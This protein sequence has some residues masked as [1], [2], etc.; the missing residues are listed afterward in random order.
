MEYN[1]LIFKIQKQNK[2]SINDTFITSDGNCCTDKN[3]I[4]NQ[5]NK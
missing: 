5:F 1:T 4:V 3:K 2:T